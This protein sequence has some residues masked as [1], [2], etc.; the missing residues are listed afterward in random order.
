MTAAEG[1]ALTQEEK[2]KAINVLAKRWLR[3]PSSPESQMIASEIAKLSEDLPPPIAC[4][5]CP[6]WKHMHWEEAGKLVTPSCPGFEAE[7]VQ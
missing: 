2:L 7:V 3:H 4:K 6:F 1:D 5:H